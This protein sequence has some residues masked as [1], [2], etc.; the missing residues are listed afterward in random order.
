MAMHLLEHHRGLIY[1]TL[2]ARAEIPA[3]HRPSQAGQR[4]PI[5]TSVP[6]T[7]QQICVNVR[8]FAGYREAAGTAKLDAP[9]AA[10]SRVRDLVELLAVRIPALVRAPGMV[11]VNQTYVTPDFEL[12]DRD[13][14]AFIPPV[15]GG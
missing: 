2:L 15:S 4:L 1:D 5:L 14:V 6:D 8:L 3:W 13:E 7:A 12:H 10:G 9:L 11:A